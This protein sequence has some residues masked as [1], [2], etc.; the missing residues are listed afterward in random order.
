ML[1][2]LLQAILSS[3]SIHQEQRAFRA[4][5]L[6]FFLSQVRGAFE[7]AMG[8]AESLRAASLMAALAASG[9]GATSGSVLLEL[10]PVLAGLLDVKVG[11]ELLAYRRT[12]T[13]SER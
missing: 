3:H 6:G 4:H 9:G 7:T 5:F 1:L 2:L 10:L 8:T 11:R 12:G 13:V